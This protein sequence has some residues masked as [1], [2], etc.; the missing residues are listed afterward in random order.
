MI[1]TLAVDK[2]YNP[3]NSSETIN[4]SQLF[5]GLVCRHMTAIQK[6]THVYLPRYF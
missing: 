5:L 6:G 3:K 1:F 2:Q 4:W